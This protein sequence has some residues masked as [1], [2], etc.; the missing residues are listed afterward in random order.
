MEWIDGKVFNIVELPSE[1]HARA[2]VELRDSIHCVPGVRA[3]LA[4]PHGAAYV[5]A[6][7]KYEPN[8]S[9]DD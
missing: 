9:Y 7:H 8:E 6:R 2:G 4:F 5:T 1:I 3:Y